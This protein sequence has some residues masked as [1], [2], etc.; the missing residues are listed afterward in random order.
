VEHERLFSDLLEGA[1]KLGVDVRV[2]PVEV[3]GRAAGGI[4]TVAGRKL[5]LLDA[6]ATA[7]QRALA[8]ASA[9]ATLDHESVYLAPK[10]RAMIYARALRNR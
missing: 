8:L 7:G 5:V 10:A 2:E 1:R 6:R 9:L 4:C 3:T